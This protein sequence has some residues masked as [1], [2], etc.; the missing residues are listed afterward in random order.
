MDDMDDIDDFLEQY[1]KKQKYDGMD[2][3]TKARYERIENAVADEG[4]IPKKVFGKSQTGYGDFETYFEILVDCKLQGIK[5]PTAQQI[6]ENMKL[7]INHYR[8]E[9]NTY[10]EEYFKLQNEIRNLKQ[11][12][13][14]MRRNNG[15]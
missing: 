6:F 13:Q 2:E 15:K 10:S 5:Y 11:D 8:A 7:Q 12:I 3:R 4:Y 1:E 14:E 9:N